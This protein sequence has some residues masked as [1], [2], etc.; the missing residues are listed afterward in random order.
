M[1][2]QVL[3]QVFGLS[4]EADCAGCSLDS[5]KVTQG[6]MFVAYRGA[7]QDGHHY[8]EQAVASGAVCVLGDSI[9]FQCSVPYIYVPNVQ[10]AL[11]LIASAY[12]QQLTAHVIALTGSVGK[13]TT[14]NM[15]YQVLQL[16]AEVYAT[17][18]NQNNEWGVPLTILNTPLS[19][20]Y[21]IV[22]CGARLP[23]DIAK[24]MTLT[25][26]QTTMITKIAESHIE[27]F[28]SLEKIAATKAEI[29]SSIGHAVVRLDE[30]QRF[31]WQSDR[32]LSFVSNDTTQNGGYVLSQD[33]G[34]YLI[35]M[36]HNGEVLT[37]ETNIQ[38]RHIAENAALVIRLAL[39]LNVPKLQIQTVLMHLAATPGRMQQ[40][41]VGDIKIIDDTYNASPL[42]VKA[43]IDALKHYEGKKMI[44]LG[45]MSELGS[46]SAD[47]H[48]DIVSYAQMTG[49]NAIMTYGK[50]YAH[51]DG[52]GVIHEANDLQL[53]EVIDRS[54]ITTILIK[55]SRAMK[56]E[57]LV[58]YLCE[59]QV[60][61][62]G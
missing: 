42:S 34:G 21:L 31:K 32:S 52:E 8:I 49:I 60:T 11:W 15:L 50:A 12:R 33:I 57:R 28:G 44:I 51:V 38:F 26:P 47:I 1:L 36:N 14:K 40:Y 61:V 30:Y 2:N 41:K 29:L 10:N 24:L 54:N 5:Q 35:D 20:N 58:K 27:T 56:M 59:E 53:Q 48:K 45:Q 25:R 62:D 7:K 39:S 16:S 18:G 23:G 9:N 6:M 22:E 4:L 37:F 17:S 19:A 46:A 55:G 13:T 3:N 43:A